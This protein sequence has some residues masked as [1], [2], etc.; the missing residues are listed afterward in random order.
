MG[1]MYLFFATTFRQH[2]VAPGCGAL[3]VRLYAQKPFQR[4][5]VRPSER[6]TLFVSSEMEISGLE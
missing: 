5:A 6:L 4:E 1:S 2:P 3:V